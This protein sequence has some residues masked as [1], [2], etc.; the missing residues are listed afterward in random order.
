MGLTKMRRKKQFIF[1]RLKSHGYST[2][3]ILSCKTWALFTIEI[4]YCRRKFR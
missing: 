1:T 4:C 3:R 2:Y